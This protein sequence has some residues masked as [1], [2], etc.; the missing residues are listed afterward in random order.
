M[1]MYVCS[2]SLSATLQS[3]KVA[4]TPHTSGHTAAINLDPLPASEA[5]V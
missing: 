1:Y 2:D 4:R 5:L 3:N